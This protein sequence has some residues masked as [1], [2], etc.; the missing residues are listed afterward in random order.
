MEKSFTSIISNV[1]FKLHESFNDPI[2]KFKKPPY[3]T[4]ERGYGSF[5]ITINISIRGLPKDHPSRQLSILHDLDLNKSQET[6]AHPITITNPGAHFM[7]NLEK[8][9]IPYER[10]S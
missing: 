7:E 9:K 10:T 2:R 8:T 6:I 5:P 4:Q 3:F 1:T